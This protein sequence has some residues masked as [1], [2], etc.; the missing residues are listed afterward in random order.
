MSEDQML[1]T[2]DLNPS[3]DDR[4]GR[5]AQIQTCLAS[6]VSTEHSCPVMDRTQ[7]GVILTSVHPAPTGRLLPTLAYARRGALHTTITWPRSWP[8]GVRVNMNLAGFSRL[9]AH[10]EWIVQLIQSQ[11]ISEDAARQQLMDMSR[12]S[13]GRPASRRKWPNW[14]HS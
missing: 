9:R 13:I 1:R 8:H 7:I 4:P 3:P 14:W 10:T 5:S 2:A 6:F 11:G 12:D